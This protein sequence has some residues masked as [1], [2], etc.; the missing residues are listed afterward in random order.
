VPVTVVF[1]RDGQRQTTT[2]TPRA[3]K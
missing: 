2:L 3:R 1:L